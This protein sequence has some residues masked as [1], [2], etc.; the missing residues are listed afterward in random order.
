MFA[1]GYHATGIKEITEKVEI[2]KGSFYNHFSTKEEFALE[3][4]RMYGENGLKMY[5]E[6]FLDNKLPPLD[7]VKKFFSTLIGD[8]S[9][10]LD[11]KLGCIMGNFSTEL[12]DTHPAFREV[13]QEEFDRHEAVIALC[14]Q[15]AKERGDISKSANPEKL[16]A[17]ILNSW[18]GA[19]L[20][21]KTTGN[22]KPLEDCRD[23]TLSILSA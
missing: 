18:H 22:A 8:Y 10:R 5:R 1:N 19:L 3:V 14:L 9:K 15:E 7:R 16:A 17:F 13:L 20:R 11:F 2:P 12:A 21:M 6:I 23:L 4:I